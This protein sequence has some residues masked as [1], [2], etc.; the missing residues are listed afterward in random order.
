MIFSYLASYFKETFR[1]MVNYYNSNPEEISEESSFRKPTG[2]KN[3]N[4]HVYVNIPK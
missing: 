2:Y 3:I 4:T 1:N